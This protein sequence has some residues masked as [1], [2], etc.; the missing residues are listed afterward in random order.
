MAPIIVFS[1]P[2][3]MI[4]QFSN[5]RFRRAKRDSGAQKRDPLLWRQKPRL[6]AIRNLYFVDSTMF[7]K[8]SNSRFAIRNSGGG[9]SRRF[10]AGAASPEEK[11]VILS[12][13]EEG[14]RVCFVGVAGNSNR[15]VSI[16][17]GW[18]V[19]RDLR[20]VNGDPR[21]SLG[22]VLGVRAREGEPRSGRFASCKQAD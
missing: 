3:R 7:R 17:M 5:L 12:R 8:N 1:L 21:P 16:R 6:F 4:E 20:I 15:G 19:T 14:R 11:S 18:L 9:G 2:A 22:R 10:R 13:L